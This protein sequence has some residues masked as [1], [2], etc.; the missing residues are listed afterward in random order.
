MNGARWAAAALAVT[1]IGVAVHAALS[2][3]RVG[4]GFFMLGIG[5]FVLGLACGLYAPVGA[6][7]D[8]APRRR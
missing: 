2:G 4:S 6:R 7:R 1:A 5:L 8:R 3:A